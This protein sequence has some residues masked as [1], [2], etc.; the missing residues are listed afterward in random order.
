MNCSS[1]GRNSMVRDAI[2]I[3]TERVPEFLINMPRRSL[4]AMGPLHVQTM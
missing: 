1:P 4:S 2:E 3:S